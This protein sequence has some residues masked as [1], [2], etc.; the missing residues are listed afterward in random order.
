M[1][2]LLLMCLCFFP[3]ASP[4]LE[5]LCQSSVLGLP[6]M[7]APSSSPSLPS[8]LSEHS[9]TLA[10]QLKS[11]PQGMI[12]SPSPPVAY[13]SSAVI[14]APRTKKWSV[15]PWGKLFAGLVVMETLIIVCAGIASVVYTDQQ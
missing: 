6:V 11:P 1:Y 4:L 8:L 7:S 3:G 2:A 13:S 10:P 15:S 14:V 9:Y 12:N 5:S